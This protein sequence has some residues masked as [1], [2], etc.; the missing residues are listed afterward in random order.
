[1]KSKKNKG[2]TLVELIITMALTVIV[3][4]CIMTMSKP[5]NNLAKVSS[6]YDSNRTVA[7]EI[8]NFVCKSIK[9]ATYADIYTNYLDLPN[10]AIS[11]FK[12][13]IGATD[14]D[15]I[16]VIAIANDISSHDP[17]IEEGMDVNNK[18]YK[19]SEVFN[20]TPSKVKFYVAMG[21]DFYGKN[22]YQFEFLYEDTEGIVT[23]KTI[24]YKNGNPSLTVKKTSK[25]LNYNNNTNNNFNVNDGL[26]AGENTYIIYTKK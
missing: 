1:M 23:I 21:K 11:D 25:F 24:T 20:Q 5:I 19:S 7:N 16:R 18:I 6:D 13:L 3:M 12:G 2:F 10:T 9:Y 4:S 15:D 26:S 17:S 8:N 14:T 22:K